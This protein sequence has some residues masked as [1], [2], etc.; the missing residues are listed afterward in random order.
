MRAP[1]L[2]DG[3]TLLVETPVI[4]DYLQRAYNSG[5]QLLPSDNAAAEAKVST[6]S[7]H[8]AAADAI[9]NACNA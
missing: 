9:I 5:T 2:V 4:V 8:V 3:P 1:L 7:A 6:M